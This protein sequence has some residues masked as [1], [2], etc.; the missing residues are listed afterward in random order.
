M[1]I[2]A[3]LD[4]WVIETFPVTQ[5]DLATA[6]RLD[7]WAIKNYPVMQPDAKRAARLDNWVIERE[8]PGYA[9]GCKESCPVR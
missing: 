8:L 2:A 9:A 6:A 5:L 3:R 1:A 4:N 7:N